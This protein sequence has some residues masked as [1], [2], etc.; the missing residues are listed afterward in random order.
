MSEQSIRKLKRRI[1][2]VSMLSFMTVMLIMG[3][4]IFLLNLAFTRA[5]TKHVLQYIAENDG[6]VPI[7]EPESLPGVRGRFRNPAFYQDDDEKAS[8]SDITSLLESLFR[9]GG[10]YS[11]PEF[12]YTTRYFA[13]L[14]DTEGVVEDVIVNHISSVDSDTALE[15][16]EQAGKRFFRFG[17]F[18]NYYYLRTNRTAGGTIVVY[19]D[20]T[21][22]IFSNARLLYIALS[23]L[24]L[25]SLITFLIMRVMVIQLM[26]PEIRNAELQ[27]Q[28]LTNASHELKTPLAVIRA[29]TELIEMTCGE[30][31]WTEATLRQVDRLQGLIDNL[32]RIT[33]AQERDAEK[34]CQ[35][36][37]MSA[38]VTETTESFR[39]VAEQAGDTLSV[40]VPADIRYYAEEGDLR[41]LVSI[42]TDNAIKYC[43]EGGE[44]RI[45]LEAAGR[46]NRGIRLLVSNSYANG[47]NVDYDR[48]FE[49]F[50]RADESHNTEKGG[51]GIGLS[52]AEQLV[53]R[54]HG[55]IRASWDQGLITFECQ[56]P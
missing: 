19:L 17:S 21:N 35:Q 20:S 12:Y 53:D 55:T 9:L 4:F 23:F 52:I 56:L 47:Q 16:A 31:E 38:V 13:V 29:N 5:E 39:T 32:V 41:Q 49:R 28:F 44:I 45:R 30:N 26:K 43:D 10:G 40:E 50:Y 42:L 22:Q 3:G 46:R 2:L 27:K 1:L 36:V 15:L 7:T 18:G 37:D 6:A 24:F 14:Y 33:R 54:Y 48:F 8:R 11:S 51:Y 25:G 34:D